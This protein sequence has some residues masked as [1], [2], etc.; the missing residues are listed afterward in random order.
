[1][2]DMFS[3]AKRSEIMSRV[4][5]RGNK[6]TELRLISIMKDYGL[7]GWRRNVHVFG[8]PDFVFPQSHLAV[9]VDGCFWHSC[10]EHHTVPAT[11]T[12]FWSAKL[13]RNRARDRA[14]NRALRRSG[15]KV[16]RIWQHELKNPLSV[17]GRL[18]RHLS[19][20]PKG[21]T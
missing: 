7:R 5:A 1:M 21:R 15:W 20:H 19:G 9:F 17:A 10:P 6:A 2:A 12:S 4:Q 16:I 3:I 14:V 13:E 18:R 8:K 11:N